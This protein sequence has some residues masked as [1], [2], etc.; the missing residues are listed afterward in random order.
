M[1]DGNLIIA[2]GGT[3]IF[4]PISPFG[5]P[6]IED[7]LETLAPGGSSLDGSDLAMS[8]VSARNSPAVLPATSQPA[9]NPVPEPD[10]LVLWLAAAAGGLLWRVR[11]PTSPLPPAKD[12]VEETSEQ[13]WMFSAMV[14]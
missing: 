1:P 5:S 9:L 6:L 2:A 12:H 13:G 11:R 10:T 3:V 7:G 4:N 8:S 14:V